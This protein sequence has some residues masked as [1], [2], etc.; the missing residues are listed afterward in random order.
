MA[1]VL[2]SECN[3][4][5]TPRGYSQHVSKSRDPHCRGG[6]T[7]QHTQPVLA[8]IPHTAFPLAID[9]NH[10]W[11]NSGRN[12]PDELGTH[13]DGSGGCDVEADEH[14]GTGSESPESGGVSPNGSGEFD[15]DVQSP[16]GKSSLRDSRCR[17]ELIWDVSRLQMLVP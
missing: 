16:D 9:L 4:F 8:S 15:H 10:G 2:C 11:Q 13:N 3:R 5:F 7:T 14:N 6:N 17:L 12:S 1:K